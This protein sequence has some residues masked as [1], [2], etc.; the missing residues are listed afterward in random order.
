M[1]NPIQIFFLCPV[2]EEQ[3]PITEYIGLKENT[4]TNWT[5]LS[6]SNYFARLISFFTFTFSLS[7]LFCKK[8][9]LGNLFF[10]LLKAD[11]ETASS[12]LFQT[13]GNNLSEYLLGTLSFLI[14]CFFL[15]LFRWKQLSTRLNESRFL[16]E[17]A[18]WYDVQIWEKPF[19]LIKNEK[20]MSTQ[21]IEPILQRLFQTLF[22]VLFS[23][24][25]VFLFS[26]DERS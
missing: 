25:L 9:Q 8:E 1:K 16:Y 22:F 20:L 24:L 11:W 4:L 21:K 2:P 18:S 19:S 6:Q 7:F 17:E 10:M 12:F 14:F 3:K 5:T 26:L 13:L 15:L 23:F